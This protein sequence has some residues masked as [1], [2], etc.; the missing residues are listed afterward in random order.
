MVESFRDA[1]LKS[2]ALSQLKKSVQWK[3]C[4]GRHVYATVHCATIGELL[5]RINVLYIIIIFYCSNDIPD[6]E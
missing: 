6:A 3:F 4:F 5:I 1:A 2:S